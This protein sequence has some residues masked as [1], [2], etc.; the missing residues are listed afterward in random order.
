MHKQQT[1]QDFFNAAAKNWDQVRKLDEDKLNQLVRLVGFAQGERVV[2]IGSGTGVLLPFIQRIIGDGG[3]ITAIDFAENML[4]IAA[5]KNQQFHNISYV[6]GDIMEL[7]PSDTFHKAIC[8]NFFPHVADKVAF[9]KKV[10]QMLVPD[11]Y[12]VIMHDISRRA[13]NEIHQSSNVVANDRLPT[14]EE[15]TELLIQVGY[16]V[17]LS[18]DDDEVYFIKARKV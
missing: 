2:D 9:A 1:E 18:L 5:V 10:Q 17:E 8:L 16:E 15:V 12:L 3:R 4:Q 6:V 7:Q 14:S 13:V 11:G